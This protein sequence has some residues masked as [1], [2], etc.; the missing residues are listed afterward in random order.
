MALKV[1]EV[2]DNLREVIKTAQSK[3]DAIDTL[4]KAKIFLGHVLEYFVEL[5]PRIRRLEKE[6][7]ELK[8]ERRN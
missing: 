5:E 4:A 7:R 1:N 8:G 6:I 2:K 3:L